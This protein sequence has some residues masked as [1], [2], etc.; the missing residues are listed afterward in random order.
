MPSLGEFIRIARRHGVEKKHGP[1]LVGP[2]GP[3]RIYYLQRKMGD[4]MVLLPDLPGDHIL[5]RDTV[6]MWCE[7]LRLPPEDYGLPP[8]EAH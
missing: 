7:T 5:K 8:Y 2:N 1:V 3:S 6:A 4:P